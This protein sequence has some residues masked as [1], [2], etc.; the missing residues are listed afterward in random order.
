[1]LNAILFSSLLILRTLTFTFWFASNT[2]ED[3]AICSSVISVIW[4]KP[5]IPSNNSTNAPNVVRRTTFPSNI[6]PSLISLPWTVHGSL[7]TSFNINDSLSFFLSILPINTS[8]L[9]PSLTISS[10]LFTLSHDKSERWINPSTPQY[11]QKL[12]T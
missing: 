5:S 11:Q 7:V 12:Q 8:T 9:S 2:S 6:S 3:F 10:G 1:M 4:T